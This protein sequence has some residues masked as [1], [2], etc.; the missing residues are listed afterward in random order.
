MIVTGFEPTTNK[1]VNKHSVWLTSLAKWFSVRLQTKW[2][3][4]RILLL[5]LKLQIWRLL[6]ARISLTFRQIIECGFTLKRTWQDNKM[7]SITSQKLG[8]QDFWWIG[9]SALGKVKSAISS[10]VWITSGI[11]LPVSLLELIWNCII[12][13]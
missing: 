8:C 13:L 2:L 1:F 5:S 3:W 9:N 11:Y 10:I 12:F 6:W 7:Q 4:V